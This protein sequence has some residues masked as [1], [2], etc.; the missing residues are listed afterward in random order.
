MPT[1]LKTRDQLLNFTSGE[2]E[3]NTHIGMI[4]LHVDLAICLGLSS[5]DKLP[6][7]PPPPTTTKLG[8]ID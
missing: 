8:H 7:P 6:P 4:L 5:S 3:F 1:E 2:H